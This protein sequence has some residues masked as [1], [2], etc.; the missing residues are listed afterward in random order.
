MTRQEE[1]QLVLT[2]RQH[3]LDEE[4]WRGFCDAFSPGMIFF[5]RRQF[6]K[7]RSD[8]EDIVQKS[9]IRFFVSGADLFEGDSGLS[10]YLNTIVRNIAI[11]VCRRKQLPIEGEPAEP[12]RDPQSGRPIE[13]LETE[14]AF[15]AYLRSL[16]PEQRKIIESRASGEQRNVKATAARQGIAPSTLYAWMAQLR[17]KAQQYL[18]GESQHA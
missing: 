14:E 13:E 4:A 9:L 18:K 8:D 10:T 15:A 2:L 7:L 3:P 11:E 6:P 5:V 12:I 17:Q 16:P 1:W